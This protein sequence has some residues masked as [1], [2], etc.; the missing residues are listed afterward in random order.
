MKLLKYIYIILYTYI[1]LIINCFIN[2]YLC[3][4][5]INMHNNN[6]NIFYTNLVT[7]TYYY[8]LYVKLFFYKFIIN[9][10]FFF[11]KN[12]LLIINLIIRLKFKVLYTHLKNFKH[13]LANSFLRLY[14]NKQNTCLIGKSLALTT[15]YFYLL[16]YVYKILVYIVVVGFF[17]AMFLLCFCCFELLLGYTCLTFYTT[18]YQI[19]EFFSLILVKISSLMPL[20]WVKAV[21]LSPEFVID[22]LGQPSTIFETL[23]SWYSRAKT[24]THYSSA[25]ILNINDFATYY[26]SCAYYILLIAQTSPSLQNLTL[27]GLVEYGL[28]I[29]LPTSVNPIPRLYKEF[30]FKPELPLLLMFVPSAEFFLFTLQYV[31]LSIFDNVN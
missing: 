19:I 29:E 13:F 10:K 5:Y 22:M 2:V 18:I 14:E 21:T 25:F 1:Q 26:E 17:I 16:T 7:Y 11:K 27:T 8:T 31:G 12:L 20:L 28:I 4:K 9:S 30:L 23:N 6:T 15:R 3:L 24:I